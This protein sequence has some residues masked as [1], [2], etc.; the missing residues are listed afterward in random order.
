MHVDERCTVKV[1]PDDICDDPMECQ[2]VFTED[3]FPFTNDP[4][5]DCKREFIKDMDLDRLGTV[6]FQV[7]SL[8]LGNISGSDDTEVD[9]RKWPPSPRAADPKRISARTPSRIRRS[10]ATDL[11]S[12]ARTSSSVIF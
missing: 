4:E 10:S 12:V 6:T 1:F 11:I 9:V 5:P 7:Q 8:F 2:A 3:Q